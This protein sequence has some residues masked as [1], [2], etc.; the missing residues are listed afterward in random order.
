MNRRSFAKILPLGAIA[1]VHTPIEAVAHGK[2]E[3]IRV[4]CEKGD[5]GERLYAELCGDKRR[6]RV[7]LDGVEQH[8]ALTADERLGI[9]RRFAMTSKGNLAFN[10][11][12]G[13]AYIEE[14]RGVVV[15]EIVG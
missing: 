11:S 15:V 9:V 3:G 10:L 6:A 8:E 4:S 1:I 14:V 5:P 12:T 7:F 13:E 2:P